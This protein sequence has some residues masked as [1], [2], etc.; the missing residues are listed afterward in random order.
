MRY[1]IAIP[2]FAEFADVRALAGLAREAQAAGWDG[3][4]I[5]DHMVFGGFP[6]ADPWI[7]LSAIA[8]ATSRIRIGPM[9]TPMP[10]RRPVK[11][12]RETIT[13]DHLSNGRLILGVGIGAGPCEYEYLG[14]EGDPKVRG[15]MLDEGL[16]VLTRIWSGEPFSFDGKHYSI[17][18]TSGWEQSATPGE[19]RFQPPSLQQ[20]RIPVWVAGTWPNKP[21]FRRAARWD[22]VYPI[23]ASKTF[24]LLTPAE[25]REISA[26]TRDH[27]GSAVPF[28]I[29]IPG[30]TEG[31]SAAADVERVAPYAEAGA[32]WWLEDLQP[33]RFGW[34]EQGPWPVEEMR[35]R[36]RCGPPRE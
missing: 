5:W 30:Q 18:G 15:E 13:L 16:E 28:D 35:E 8:L 1:G 10:R 32:T 9:V 7:A 19:A 14:E 29:V 26:Y 12:A 23:K 17:H 36:V 20:P 4:F 2:P 3:F 34:Q 24:E 27:R 33:W 31:D 22:G 11:L 6:I 25:V 21:P